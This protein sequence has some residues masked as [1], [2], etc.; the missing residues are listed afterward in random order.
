MNPLLWHDEGIPGK[1]TASMQAAQ[2]SPVAFSGES[3]QQALARVEGTM[4]PVKEIVLS[5]FAGQPHYLMVAD[6]GETRIVAPQRAVM[7]EFSSDHLLTEVA[8]VSAQ[9]VAQTRFVTAYEPYYVDRDGGLRLPALFVEMDDAEQTMHYVDPR[10]G[11]VV[12]SY[13]RR[14]RWNRWLY[15]GLHSFD[16]P[17]LYRN[18]PAWDGAVLLLMLGG[19][20][21]TITS[22]V[23]GWRRIRRKMAGA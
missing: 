6:G 3:P 15:H 11:T 13:D 23:I 1:L 19:T 10:T 18:R 14:G 16:L 17:W 12:R 7:T 9:R 5:F 20:A 4:G 8:R 2:W 21:L 22:L